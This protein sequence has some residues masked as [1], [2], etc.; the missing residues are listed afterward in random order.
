ME[1]V[2]VHTARARLSTLIQKVLNGEDII[3]AESGRPLVRLVA[4]KDGAIHR[5]LGTMRGR[6]DMSDDFDAPL[7]N[8]DAPQSGGMY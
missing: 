2:S 3:I 1:V 5:R 8:F 4:C 6:I 7:E